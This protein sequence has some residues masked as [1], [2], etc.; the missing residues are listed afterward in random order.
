MNNRNKRYDEVK[1]I[2]V[3][4]YNKN[5]RGFY[6]KK[7]LYKQAYHFS[8]FYRDFILK[9]IKSGSLKIKY[10]CK[11]GEYYPDAR[12]YTSKLQKRGK[13]II[14]ADITNV[15]VLPHEIGHASDFWFGE[16]Q[17]LTS[18][19]ILSNGKTLKEIF[20]EEFDK[21]FNDIYDHVM[22]EY[23][24]IVNTHIQKDAYDILTSNRFVY[25]RLL[26]EKGEARKVDQ[27]FLYKQGFVEVYYQLYTKG[28]YKLLNNK[29]APILD[30]LSSRMDLT[31]LFLVGHS[32]EYYRLNDSRAVEEFYANLFAVK[33][34]SEHVKFKEL[35]RLL[36]ESFAAFE[37]LFYMFYDRIQNNKR[38]TDV[39]IRRETEEKHSEL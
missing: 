27:G 34:T 26:K 1:D 3:A 29:Y 21:K 30:A 9:L 11:G 16:E 28:Y 25:K 13:G 33:V 19:V 8:P 38:F 32:P 35:K 6:S 20:N 37:E 14:H 17:S 23:K 36:P 5:K 31:E 12:N 10:T 4:L 7:W 39:T 24:F 18:N 2:V 22:D 15:D